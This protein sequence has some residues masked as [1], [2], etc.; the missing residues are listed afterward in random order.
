VKRHIDGVENWKRVRVNALITAVGM[1]TALGLDMATSCASARTGL[2]RAK[3]LGILKVR[4]PEDGE[5]EDVVGHG[6]EGLKGFEGQGRL[7]ALASA[8][9]RDLFCSRDKGSI[10][11]KRC[12]IFMGWPDPARTSKGIDLI[13]DEEVKAAKKQIGDANAEVSENKTEGGGALIERLISIVSLPASPSSCMMIHGEHEAFAKT[14]RAAVTAMESGEID[15]AIVGAVDSLIDY[16]TLI[17]LHQT[18]RLKCGEMP[19]G[20]QPGEAAVFM[21]LE[22]PGKADGKPVNLSTHIAYVGHAE[23]ETTLLSGHP[24]DGTGLSQLLT[25]LEKSYSRFGT[26]VWILTDQNGEPYR[27]Y[28]W[29]LAQTRVAATHP[30]ITT[31]PVSYP[32]ISFGDTGAACGAVGT[33]LAMSAFKR[34]YAPAPTAWVVTSSY[35]GCHGALRV[36]STSLVR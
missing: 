7:I 16:E 24:A 15:F 21:L 1:V 3:Q 31:H 10:N 35:D 28:E 19:V 18:G 23:Q 14:V 27:A 33:C 36:M 13:K 2:T 9:M 26:E 32:V 20:L 17:W 30:T 6:V 4:N 25:D 34:K 5:L 8:G 22:K 11:W 12:G 29:G